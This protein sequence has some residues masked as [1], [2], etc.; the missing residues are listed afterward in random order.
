MFKGPSVNSSVQK[1]IGLVVYA[2]TFILQV[3]VFDIRIYRRKN[4]KNSFRMLI[5]MDKVLW[6]KSN[7]ILLL[8][9][10]YT[11]LRNINIDECLASLVA[12][13]PAYFA[14][15]TKCWWCLRPDKK[16]ST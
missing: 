8:H 3:S 5:F 4:L 10:F 6:I 14:T 15:T 12:K 7:T 11:S 16:K 9:M 1:K 13:I 2:T